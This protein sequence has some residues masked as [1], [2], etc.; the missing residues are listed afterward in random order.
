MQ[1]YGFFSY[2]YFPVHEK[3]KSQKTRIPTYFTQEIILWNKY[4]RLL[5]NPIIT[6]LLMRHLEKAFK[7]LKIGTKT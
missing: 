3:Y 7:N 1:E 5:L 4:E 2:P 6:R